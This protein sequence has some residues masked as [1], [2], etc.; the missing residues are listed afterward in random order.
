MW[1]LAAFLILSELSWVSCP[2]NWWVSSVTVW[3]SLNGLG[4]E[5]LMKVI[6]KYS[7]AIFVL[8]GERKII[9]YKE[10]YI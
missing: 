1:S 5:L 6:Y 8:K 9:H 4:I 10:V 7:L 3:N 2:R